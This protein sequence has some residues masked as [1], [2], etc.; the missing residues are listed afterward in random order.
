MLARARDERDRRPAPTSNTPALRCWNPAAG[1]TL[2][3]FSA[4]A[5]VFNIG[6]TPVWRTYSVLTT[7]NAYKLQVADVLR[8]IDG[9]APT[10]LQIVDDIVDIQAEYGRDANNDGRVADTEWSP[11]TPANAAEWQQVL[12]I[13]VGVLARSGNYEQTGSAGQRVRC[14]HGESRHG[15]APTSRAR[16][17]S[18]RRARSRCPAACRAATSTACSRR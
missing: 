15:R 11:T 16:P 18:S 6:I 4:G 2:P 14:D 17:R 1:S 7:A 3:T 10:P 13:R 8:V 5:Y 9:S 12:A